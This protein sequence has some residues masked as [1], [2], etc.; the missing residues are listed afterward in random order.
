M[1]KQRR[2]DL[3]WLRVCS[4][5]A[6]FL[7]HVCMPFNGDDFH[8]MNNESSKILDDIMVYFE[9]FRLPIL[10]LV[11]GV[12]TVFAFSKKTWYQ[13]IIERIKR[14]VIPLAFGVLVIVPP[15]V[16]YE[17]Y[18]EQSSF[19]KVL[20]EIVLQNKVNH[21]WF[22]EQLFV[23]SLLFIPIILLMNSNKRFLVYNFMSKWSQ[24]FGIFSWVVI[25]I[26]LRV[27]SKFYFPSNSNSLT[28]LSTLV[29]Y[30][31]FFFS[32]IVIAKNQ[33]VWLLLQ[34][35]RRKNLFLAFISTVVF[36][37]YY[38]MPTDVISPFLS[39]HHR[40]N[41]WYIVCCLVSWGVIISILGYSSVYL[42]N[43][44][45]VL[46]KLNEA[47]YP[48]YILHQ[49][50]I[51]IFGYYIINNDLTLII[52]LLLLLISSF[53]TIGVIYIFFIKPFRLIRFLFGMKNR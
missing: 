33:K 8:I 10:F 5:F 40:W 12:G 25:L 30:A 14:L 9:Q 24:K 53:F 34:K 2:Y 27:L 43:K 15:Q 7:H 28:N 46:S 31:F 51:I 13:F 36:Y 42:N 17:E 39:L 41:L 20:P 35:N 45:K 19:F 3:D 38:F 23:L 29:F 22:I 21:L 32:G 52:K 11:S 49:T 1:D 50:V 18:I 47:V 44:S 48:F 16:Y 26:I 37:V 6:V 4:V